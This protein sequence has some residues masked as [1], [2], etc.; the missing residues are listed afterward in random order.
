MKYFHQ[1]AL[2]LVIVGGLNWGLYAFNYN[3]VELLF[4]SV[5]MLEQAV[6]VLVALSA[7]Y[8]AYSHWTECKTC[9]V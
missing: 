1:V 9:S 7:V 8:L 6:Y 4:G 3:L 5:P 2:L